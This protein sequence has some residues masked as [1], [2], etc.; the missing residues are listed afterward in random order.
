[1][2]VSA[3]RKPVATRLDLNLVLNKKR[4]GDAI[5]LEIYRGRQKMEVTVTLGES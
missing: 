1:V 4:P 3:D 5:T 2:I